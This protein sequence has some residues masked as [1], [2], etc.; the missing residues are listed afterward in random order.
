[1]IGNCFDIL[2]IVPTG[3]TKIII[4]IVVLAVVNN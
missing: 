3:G 1:M 4:N 2:I